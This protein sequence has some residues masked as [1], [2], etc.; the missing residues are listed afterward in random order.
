MSLQGL[1]HREVEFCRLVARL[2]DE[3]AHEH[4]ERTMM[5]LN[6]R[7]EWVWHER[8]DPH[9]IPEGARQDWI[10]A[11][12]AAP[13]GTAKLR[14]KKMLERPEIRDAI[15][16][17]RGNIADLARE[18]L[19]DTMLTGTDATALRAAGRILQDEEKIREKDEF[20]RW[21]EIACQVGMKMEFDHRPGE[22]REIH[23]LR[24][25]IY[26]DFEGFP[27]IDVLKKTR[28]TLTDLIEML[29]ARELEETA[30]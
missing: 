27:S 15:E 3:K 26:T 1:Q 19:V 17:L 23:D 4:F 29:E 14:S 21:C 10:D 2:G 13:N 18:R 7:G 12:P 9:E 28:D 25:A 6:S 11:Q 24:D 20:E 30:E 16:A 22:P 8:I 5:V